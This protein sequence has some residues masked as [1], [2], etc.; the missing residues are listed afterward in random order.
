MLRGENGLAKQV[1]G[2]D[3]WGIRGGSAGDPRGIH[4]V[5]WGIRPFCHARGL[6][7]EGDPVTPLNATKDLEV[8]IEWSGGGNRRESGW[9]WGRGA[10]PH[11]VSRILQLAS[12]LSVS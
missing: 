12:P 11:Q 1:S 5:K 6:G 2:G 4:A 8:A 9:G 3:P 7:F 10:G